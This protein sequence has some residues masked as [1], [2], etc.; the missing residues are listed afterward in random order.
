MYWP[1][2][3]DPSILNGTW[4]PPAVQQAG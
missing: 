1:K 2:D 4:N 3:K